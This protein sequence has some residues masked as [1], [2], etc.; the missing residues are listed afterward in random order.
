MSGG[1]EALQNVRRRLR[2]TVKVAGR[3]YYVAEGDLLL[4]E[5][6]LRTYAERGQ[7]FPEAE[8]AVQGHELVAVAPGGKI[9]RWRPGLEL[10]YAI[11]RATF[12]PAEYEQARARMKEATSDWEATCGV[13]F[14]H[15]ADR[16]GEGSPG[17]VL[18][19]VTEGGRRRPVHRRRVFPER[20]A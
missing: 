4:D 6:A 20:T 7:P 15:R 12:S 14:A 11:L 17:D 1:D 9:A 13:K 16:D 5:E 3:E 18:F 10:S 2:R 8:D 19:T